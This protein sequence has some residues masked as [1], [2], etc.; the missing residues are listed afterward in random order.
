MRKLR[1]L[2]V[3]ES[4]PTGR[5]VNNGW[6]T[7]PGCSSPCPTSASWKLGVGLFFC[8][9]SFVKYISIYCIYKIT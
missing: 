3:K 5:P 7:P 6:K 4:V 9:F 8:N 2:V 1:H